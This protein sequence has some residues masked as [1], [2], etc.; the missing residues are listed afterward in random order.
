[1]VTRCNANQLDVKTFAKIAHSFSSSD[2]KILKPSGGLKLIY[3]KGKKIHKC[4]LSIELPLTSKVPTML[5][6]S[7]LEQSGHPAN[8]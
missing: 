7:T 1:M 4:V 2:F 8:P 3:Q 6:S 5:F